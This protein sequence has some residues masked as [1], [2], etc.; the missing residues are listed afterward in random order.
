MIPGRPNIN[1]PLRLTEA[2]AGTTFPASNVL[3]LG[4]PQPNRDHYRIGI[5][6]DAI[7]LVRRILQPPVPSAAA[8]TTPTP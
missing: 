4:V 1:T 3:L 2:P 5:A 7:P 8:D 6:F